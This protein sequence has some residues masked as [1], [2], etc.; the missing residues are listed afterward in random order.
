MSAAN[1][2]NTLPNDQARAAL[3]NCCA[4]TRWVEEMLARRLY[5]DDAALFTASEAVAAKLT[6][7]DWL[8]AFAAHPLIGDVESLRN[9]YAATKS[10]AAG[11][12]SGVATASESTLQELATLNRAYADRF[13]FIF[14]VFATGKTADEMLA[15]LNSRINNAR[16][17]ELKTAAAEQLKITTLRLQ[18]LATS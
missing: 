7:P 2:L 6:E 9:K 8:E 5:A 4:S 1:L 13:G 11:E 3:T 15:I 16:E 10:I 12:Q 14:I 17:Q 18:T